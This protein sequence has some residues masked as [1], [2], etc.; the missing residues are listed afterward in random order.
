MELFKLFGKL[1]IE[2]ADKANSDITNVSTNAQKSSS[3]VGKLGSA[4]QNAFKSKSIQEVDTSV[5]KLTYRMTSQQNKVDLLKRKYADLYLTH[6]KNS[7]EAKECAAEIKKLSGELQQ[8]EKALE[9]AQSAADKYD[10]SLDGVAKN[11]EK[12]GSKIVS[13]F[14]SIGAAV[15]AYFAVDK[16][17]E[18]AMACVSAAA[19]AEAATAQFSQV[20]GDLEGQA[21]E[22]LSKIANE[23]GIVE[24]RMKG[25]FT[26]IAAFAKT[27]GMSTADSLSLAERAMV[28]VADSAAFYD[29][30]LEETT[31]SLQSFLKGNFEND[32]ALGLSCTETTR[33]AAANKL[34]GQSFADLS[35]A[36]KQLTLLQMVEDANA[37][38][39]ALGQASRESD[40]WTNQTGNLNQAWT[41]FTA[42]IGKK[43]LPAAIAVVG[44]LSQ[45]VQWM[46]EHETAVGVITIAVGTLTAAIIAY[47]IAQNAAT[48]ATT[49]A[50][51]ATAAFGAVMSFVTSP[52]TL[53]V[54]AIGALIAIIYLC[55]KHWDDIK[56]A[57]CNACEWLKNAWGTVANWFREK[58]TEPIANFFKSMVNSIIGAINGMI[59][60]VI[61]GVNFITRALNKLSF[62][63]PDWVPG[64][65]GK[66][67]GFNIGEITAP[68][69]PLLEQG[70]VLEKGQVGLLEGNGAEAVVPLHQNKKWISAVAD[71]MDNA[72]SGSDTAVVSV[73]Q[74]I[75]EQLK[76]IANSGNERIIGLLALILDSMGDDLK[77]QISSTTVEM[78]NRVVGRVV[79][80][81]V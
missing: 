11:S 53:V 68:Q 77:E 8:N 61:S 24:N 76:I 23:S 64:L 58:V 9:E 63:V 70:A 75:L 78:D 52:I 42:T 1:A 34:Y 22:T 81:L 46:T 26:K 57:A 3:A 25:S 36:Q 44:T 65:G 45:I 30:S 40:T 32:A 20:F 27:T 39:G 54:L 47:N 31:E 56:L 73:L 35:E 51:A 10:K 17:K 29:R 16:I 28:A 71:D 66:T 80:R 62:D 4:I 59:S 55:V 50:T 5:E 12:F 48:I 60:G 2:G 38:S 79:R 72:T 14:K 13:A 15:A 43:F 21:S 41:D 37:L 33:N 18:F 7:K 19:D 67:F 74:E 69:I 49:I 6:G